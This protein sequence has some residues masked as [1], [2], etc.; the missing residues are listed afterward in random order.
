MGKFIF[1]IIVCF[2]SSNNCCFAQEGLVLSDVIRE[3]REAQ[4]RQAAAEKLEKELTPIKNN[5]TISQVSKGEQNACEKI[6]PEELFGD[7]K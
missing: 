7:K 1:C 4:L 2:L 6:N 5:E 3:A